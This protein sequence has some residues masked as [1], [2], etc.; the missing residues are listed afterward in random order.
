MNE[1]EKFK[2][3]AELAKKLGD[4]SV[5]NNNVKNKSN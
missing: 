1:L 2:E 4:I 3:R 5:N